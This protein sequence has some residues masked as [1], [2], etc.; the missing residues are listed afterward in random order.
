[1]LN[2]DVISYSAPGKLIL[3]G[4]HAVVYGK[5]ALICALDMRL[6]FTLKHTQRS[7]G[8]NKQTRVIVE[9]THEFLR[10]RKIAF[11]PAAAFATSIHS[12]IP[13]GRNLGSSAALSVAA[14][15]AFL[16]FYTSR[17]PAK[18]MINALAYELEK[19]FHGKP[20]GADNST[21]CFGGLVYYRKEFEFLKNISALS[22]K[23]PQ[24]I[25]DHLLIINSGKSAE[26]TAEM[27]AMVGKRY[28]ENSSRM[29]AAMSDI[30]RATKK[31]TLAIAGENPHMFVEAI[32]Q[33]Q[34]QLETLG[35]VSPTTIQLLQSLDTH[36][37]GKVTGGGGATR[38][39]GNILFFAQDPDKTKSH[40][41]SQNISF[42]PLHQDHK[43]VVRI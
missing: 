30:E 41:Q 13:A 35:V 15:A 42:L 23:I 19:H 33:N 2:Q 5:P 21:S 27:V 9:R 31:M 36:G 43:G 11:D 26:S 4:E 16:H 20:S 14:S 18:D 38:G 17:E 40:L 24:N 22:M 28:N 6:R 3:S 34:R 39:S 1:M 8:I 12:D 25:L 37:V 10:R 7:W 32:E 29:E